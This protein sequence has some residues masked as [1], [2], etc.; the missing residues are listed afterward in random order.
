MSHSQTSFRT[1]PY[2]LYLLFDLALMYRMLASDSGFLVSL[3]RINYR[4]GVCVSQDLSSSL[5]HTCFAF[6]RCLNVKQPGQFH[7]L[8]VAVVVRDSC[9][10]IL[11]KIQFLELPGIQERLLASKALM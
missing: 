8:V 10:F 6:A 1:F 3:L 7:D 5:D 9:W 2:D 4:I 11:G